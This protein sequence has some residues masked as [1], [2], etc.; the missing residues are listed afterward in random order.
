MTYGREK[1]LLLGLLAF[2]APLPLPFNE[3]LGWPTLALYL[4]AVG[5]F[6]HRARRDEERWLPLWASNLA[7]VAYLPVFLLDLQAGMSGVV[8]R[9]VLRLGLFAV[10]VKLFSL[11]SERDKWH[12]L[13]GVFF[14]FLASVATSVHLTVTIY[15]VVF[16]GLALLVLARF[17]LL[18]LLAGFGWREGRPL[19]VPLGR[20][21]AA[22][23]VA[24]AV[25]AV[26]LFAALPR[27][28][29][30]FVRGPIGGGGRGGGSVTGYS[31]QVNLDSIGRLRE[32]REVALRLEFAGEPPGELRL[33]GGTYE[34]FRSGRWL[35][36]P[37]VRRGA[38]R[39]ERTLTLGS[40]TVVGQARV[41]RMPLAA[42]SLPLPVETLRVSPIDRH[43][44]LDR[45]GGVHLPRRIEDPLEYTVELAAAPASAAVDPEVGSDAATLD[46]TGVTPEMIDLAATVAG[47]APLGEKARRL[48][49]YL[50]DNYEYTLDLVGRPGDEAIQRFLFDDRRGHCEYF[51]SAL[52]LLLRSQGVHAR[53]VTGF[54]GGERNAL[55]L[56]VVRQSN[57]HA[58][59]E[60]WIPGEGWRTLD[61]TPPSGR[62][63]AA[64]GVGA[65][66]AFAN[67]YD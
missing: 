25:L 15:V 23:T 39:S 46:L 44:N 59:V 19:R 45:G 65:L 56:H 35:P 52:V 48:E 13:F 9:P 12:A 24:T 55:G 64:G 14:L 21:V 51:A 57:A 16:L 38:S 43:A 60:A 32:N 41:F 49:R 66:R 20:F 28:S 17:A 2:V 7:A 34:R 62:P 63:D 5:L 37:Y 33:K 27:V 4:A 6:L 30:P 42:A 8:V 54:L 36:S 61:P 50:I 67:L 10:A 53:L 40:G 18:H 11:R 58:W 22:V 47:T 31:D 3:L 26:P 1:R 29:T